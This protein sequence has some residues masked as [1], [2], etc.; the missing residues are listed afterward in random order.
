MICQ[1]NKRTPVSLVFRRFLLLNKRLLKKPTFVIVILLIPLIALSL[2][3]LSEGEAGIVTVALSRED[4]NDAYAKKL[5]DE[6]VENTSLISFIIADDPKTAL[7]TV[8]SGKADE[9]WIFRENSEER[10]DKF[11]VNHKKINAL[12]DCVNRKD[13]MFL[14]IAREK[15]FAVLF[16][17]CTIPVYLNFIDSEVS[18]LDG[19]D[20]ETL[21]KY[22]ET[23]NVERGLFNQTDG[24]SSFAM[25]KQST[26][27]VSAPLRGL[28]ASCVFLLS[29]SVCIVAVQDR[30]NGVF[31]QLP[32]RSFPVFNLFYHISGLLLALVTM[33][34]SLY[35]LGIF[36]G[37]LR[38]IICLILYAFSLSGFGMILTRTVKKISVLGTLIPILV[39]AEI[40]ICP[41]F[42]NF[43]SMMSVA[44]IFPTYYYLRAISSDSYILYFAIYALVTCTAGGIADLLSRD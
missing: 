38:E 6:I 39:I 1:N 2:N 13:T 15:L 37:F 29:L 16:S 9:A 32:K 27:Y 25:P 26:D 20:S 22:Y 14:K 11:S 21:L 10:M 4:E 23:V 31:I 35:A 41:I 28:C 40:I 7:E 3:F 42:L 12:V 18:E 44:H 30:K 8:K 5:C 34:L 17:N 43:N 33:L 19:F 24:K 36:V